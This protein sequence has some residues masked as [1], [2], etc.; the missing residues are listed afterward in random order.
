VRAPTCLWRLNRQRVPKR[1]H[2]KFRRR[3]I[4]QRKQ[5]HFFS[6]SVWPLLPIQRRYRGLLLKAWASLNKSGMRD[7][8]L[9]TRCH[10]G[11]RSSGHLFSV[12]CYS[13]ATNELCVTSQKNED[14][15]SRIKNQVDLLLVF[16]T[17]TTKRCVTFRQPQTYSEFCVLLAVYPCIILYIK[18]TWCAFFLSMFI[19]FL[20]MFRANMCPSSGETT[21][22]MRHLVLVILCGWVSGMCSRQSS[23]QKQVFCDTWYLFFCVDE[24]LVCVADSH[25]HRN[26]FSATLGT[27][28]SV[29]MSVWYVYQT[30][31]HTE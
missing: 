15:K 12:N 22:F 9:P 2:I 3:G 28:Y 26:K 21:V 30:V 25:P 20:Y 24:C 31:I 6:F 5:Q 27:C 17:P 4:T 7:F 13:D 10:W 29:W 11:L 23:T 18:S 14:P 1:R 8:R 16:V 19:P